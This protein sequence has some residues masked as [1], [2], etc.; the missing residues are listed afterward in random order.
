MGNEYFEEDE[1]LFVTIT[2]E[3][4]SEIECRVL[5]IFEVEDQDYI[6]LLSVED[7]DDESGEGEVFIYRY[8][9]DEEGNPG[10]DNIETEEE[11]N[12]VAEVF[13]QIMEDEELE[14]EE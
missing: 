10:L 6:V 9:E 4:D 7:E 3:D 2:L 5:T 1:D 13:E 11:F 8:F 14:D 12:M